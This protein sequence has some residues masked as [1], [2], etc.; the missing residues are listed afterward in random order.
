MGKTVLK[1][2]THF[3]GGQI[4]IRYCKCSDKDQHGKYLMK[5]YFRGYFEVI[6][7][8]ENVCVLPGN[9]EEKRVPITVAISFPFLKTILFFFFCTRD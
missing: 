5:E 2:F 4:G 1:A 6:F 3:V 7:L 9:S 8:K